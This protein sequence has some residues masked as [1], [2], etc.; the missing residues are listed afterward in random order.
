MSKSKIAVIHLT[1]FVLINS[2][3]SGHLK[4]REDKYVFIYAARN[5]AGTEYGH[6][7]RNSHS[8]SNAMHPWIYTIHTVFQNANMPTLRFP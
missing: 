4:T 5:S 1:G 6:S 7:S 3:N 2:V 8:N